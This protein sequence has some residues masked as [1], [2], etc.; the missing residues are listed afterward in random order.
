MKNQTILLIVTIFVSVYL[1]SLLIKYEIKKKKKT[2]DKKDKKTT[3]PKEEPVKEE[4]HEEP[5]EEPKTVTEEKKETK[6]KT[7]PIS[8]ALLDELHEFQNYLKERVT[9]QNTTQENTLHPYDTPRFSALDD[10]SYQNFEDDLK[11]YDYLRRPQK[12]TS[13]EDLP[14]EIKILLFTNLFDTKF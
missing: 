10:Y 14:N 2:K 1:L 3:Q 13:L 8:V 6:E 4:A 11:E 7:P 12:S 9:P 5:K